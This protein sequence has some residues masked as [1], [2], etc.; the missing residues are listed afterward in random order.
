MMTIPFPMG[1]LFV[2]GKIIQ[3]KEGHIIKRLALIEVEEHVR[4]VRA[5]LDWLYPAASERQQMLAD[6]HDIG[7]KID[8]R[9]SYARQFKDSLK[10]DSEGRRRQLRADFLGQLDGTEITPSQAAE[11]YVAF[12][13]SETYR[14]VRTWRWDGGYNYRLDS[15][16]GGFHASTVRLN[17]LPDDLAE[18]ERTYI[19]EVIR[20]HHT[21][22]P[23]RL[24]EVAA[25]YGEDVLHDLY[26]LIV[27]DHLGSEWAGRL[28]DILEGN[29]VA[30]YKGGMRFAEFV[31]E[32][33]GEPRVVKRDGPAVT[34]Q[35][36]LGCG[37]KRLALD[38]HYYLVDFYFDGSKMAQQS[39]RRRRSKR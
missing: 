29:E 11:A 25:E 4:H 20:L 24:I 26:R 34:G 16:F 30:V 22:R 23:D 13:K 18:Q 36:H 6:L 17:D 8:L 10:Q 12:L 21:F 35:V 3:L 2:P 1:K 33:E 7:K 32:A 38:V 15:P 39:K 5:M 27:C 19:L 37:N 31:V 14:H 28:V 9:W